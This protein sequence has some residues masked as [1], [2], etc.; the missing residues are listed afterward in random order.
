MPDQFFR[1]RFRLFRF[2]PYLFAERNNIP[3]FAELLPFVV[4]DPHVEEQVL[5]EFVRGKHVGRNPHTG[6]LCQ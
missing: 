6:G 2:D 4:Y 1:L 5:R 3:T